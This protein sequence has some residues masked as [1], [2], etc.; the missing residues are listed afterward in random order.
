MKDHLDKTD[1]EWEDLFIDYCR[2]NDMFERQYSE[3]DF[4]PYTP[5]EKEYNEALEQFKKEY[6]TEKGQES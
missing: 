1:A 5:S 4:R 3:T 6:I 2:E